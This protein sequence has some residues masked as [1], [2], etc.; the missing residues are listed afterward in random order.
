MPQTWR[1]FTPSPPY[2]QCPF[3]NN[4]FQKGASLSD[5]QS[6]CE[7]ESIRTACDVFLLLVV[8]HEP[9]DNCAWKASHTAASLPP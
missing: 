6:E 1:A 9:S 2:G 4:T 7:M 5:L 8:A 3:E